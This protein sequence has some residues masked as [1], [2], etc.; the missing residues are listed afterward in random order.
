[1]FKVQGLLSRATV[2]VRP[3]SCNGGVI[4]IPR[5]LNCKR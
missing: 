2:G 5:D 3:P 1:M 4:G